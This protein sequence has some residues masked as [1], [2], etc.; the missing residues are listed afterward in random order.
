MYMLPVLCPFL[1]EVAKKGSLDMQ[2]KAKAVK[3]CFYNLH[4]A[5]VLASSKVHNKASYAALDTACG[6]FH[7]SYV[8]VSGCGGYE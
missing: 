4:E 2:T 6:V 5:V 8:E 7:D 1:D 3:R